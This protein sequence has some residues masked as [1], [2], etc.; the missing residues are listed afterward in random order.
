M[1][2]ALPDFVALDFETADYSRDSACAVALVRV[3]GGEIVRRAH[4]LIRP[5]RQRF[6]FTHLHGIS[7]A[8]VAGEPAFGEVWPELQ[9]VLAGARFIAAHY[10][11]FDRSVLR[12]CCAAAGLAMPA[13]PFLCTVQLAR[14]TWKLRRANLPAVC[15][16]LD[17]AL[18]HHRA[19]SDAEACARIVLA[20]ASAGAQV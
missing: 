3:S 5:P 19:D 20:A 18:R 9:E 8:D 6:V 11:P 13:Q 4:R 15:E 12:A 14:R 10:A 1:S 16:H 2:A 17:L 7:W